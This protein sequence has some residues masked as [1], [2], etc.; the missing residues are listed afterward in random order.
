MRRW[1]S[2][3]A[4]ADVAP[5]L[6]TDDIHVENFDEAFTGGPY[7]GHEGLK[8]WWAD[9]EE[10]FDEPR[11][12]FENAIDLEDG[13]VLTF[14]RMIGRFK[15]TGIDL[16][17]PWAAIMTTRDGKVARAVGYASRRQALRDAGLRP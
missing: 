6:C 14:Q 5:E 9:L 15:I 17:L 2:G 8:Q 10:M 11:I 13:R 16:D 1:V 3:F 7:D 12:E 4:R